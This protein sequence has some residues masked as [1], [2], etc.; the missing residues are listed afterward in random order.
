MSGG[1]GG[2][3]KQTTTSEPWKESVPYIKNVFADASK[4]YQG[5]GYTPEMQAVNEYQKSLFPGR[6]EGADLMKLMAYDTVAGRYDAT[7]N[8]ARPVGVERVTVGAKPEDIVS[9]TVDPTAARATQGSIDPTSALADLLTGQVNQ[10]Y[11]DPVAETI[12]ANVTRNALENIL[13]A[14]RS[15]A[16]G[17]GQYGS[18]RQGVAEGLAASRLNQDLAT[19]IAP[20]YAQAFENAQ[21]R[22]TGVA[23]DLNRQ[24]SEIAEMNAGRDLTAQQFN[25]NMGFQQNQLEA[26]IA[27]ANAERALGAG[28]F[29]ANLTLQEN[30]QGMANQQAI[31]QNRLKAS[32]LYGQAMNFQDIG[33]DQYQQLLREPQTYA[34]ERLGQ[35]ASIITPGAGLGGSSTQTAKQGR[36]PLTSAAGGAMMGAS[37]GGGTGAAAGALLGLVMG[38]V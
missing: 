6:V 7:L 16:L 25:A 13:P 3:G 18:S 15:Q 22:K 38:L 9:Q 14:I 4:L 10:Q 12:R 30:Q 1:K 31:L 32:D 19:A 21:N 35:Y 11:L 24:A 5:G 27:Q 2:G 23:T 26:A 33:Y 37:V 20:M 29:N 17:A 34:Q 28:Q 36:N 8:K